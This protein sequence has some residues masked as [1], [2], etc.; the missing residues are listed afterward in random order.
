MWATGNVL[1][2]PQEVNLGFKKIQ[3]E[4]QGKSLCE[5][6]LESLGVHLA[7]AVYQK[8]SSLEIENHAIVS[9]EPFAHPQIFAVVCRG[10]LALPGAGGILTPTVGPNCRTQRQEPMVSSCQVY[11]GHWLSSCWV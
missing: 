2:T 1:Q 4:D 11:E 6:L 9:L 10:M 5:R 3:M 7:V 8:K